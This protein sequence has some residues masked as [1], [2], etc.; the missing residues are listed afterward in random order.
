MLE[1]I[2]QACQTVSLETYIFD[3]DEAGWPSRGLWAPR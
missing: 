2:D 1:A 3:R